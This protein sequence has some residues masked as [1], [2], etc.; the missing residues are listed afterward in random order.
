MKYALIQRNI[1]ITAPLQ[2]RANQHAYCSQIHKQSDNYEI[3][4]WPFGGH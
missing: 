4:E 1:E 3:Y 2:K